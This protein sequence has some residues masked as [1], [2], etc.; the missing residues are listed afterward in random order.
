MKLP[1]CVWKYRDLHSPTDIT[2]SNGRTSSKARSEFDLDETRCDLT[3]KDT[4]FTDA[5]F[6]ECELVVGGENRRQNSTWLTVMGLLQCQ[7]LNKWSYA[8][9]MCVIIIPVPNIITKWNL[10][11]NNRFKPYMVFESNSLRDNR[12]MGSR[13]ILVCSICSL[14]HIIL[15][16]QW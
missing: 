1:T 15:L 8:F 13:V 9:N 14:K 2:I 6:Y 7:D 12:T 4:W 10:L 11:G 16:F 3:I 5:G